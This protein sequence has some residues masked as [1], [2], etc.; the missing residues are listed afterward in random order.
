M[1]LNP[2]LSL[3]APDHISRKSPHLKEMV[4]SYSQAA[5][6][7]LLFTMLLFSRS[8]KS[9]LEMAVRLTNPLVKSSIAATESM[10]I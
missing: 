4:L 8:M 1:M 9:R 7:C 10:K 3:H 6:N 2:L 5:L